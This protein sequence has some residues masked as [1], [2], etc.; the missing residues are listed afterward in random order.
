MKV[1]TFGRSQT[2]RT[3]NGKAKKH[4]YSEL[5]RRI[6]CLLGRGLWIVGCVDEFLRGGLRIIVV[7]AGLQ[8]LIVFRDGALAIA[9]GVVSIAALDVGPGIDPSRLT[10]HGVQCSLKIIERQLPI[11]L[12]EI[13]QAE[14]V[15]DPGVVAIEFERRFQLLLC[16]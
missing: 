5:A 2:F 12:F 11:L 1:S 7:A 3:S 8:S 14:I 9:L 10:A 6:V 16:F 13:N 4:K 15:I